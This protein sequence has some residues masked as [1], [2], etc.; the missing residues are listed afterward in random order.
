[1]QLIDTKSILK[2]LVRNGIKSIKND[3]ATKQ[4]KLN[5]ARHDMKRSEVLS[6]INKKKL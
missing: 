2:N 1:M 3:A 6:Y 4:K 5:Q